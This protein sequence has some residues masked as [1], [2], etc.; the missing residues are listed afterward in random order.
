MLR[1][2]LNILAA[3]ALLAAAPSGSAA[4]EGDLFGKQLS[5][6]P[7]T[8]HADEV[9]YEPDRD[10][11]EAVGHVRIEQEGGGTL[12]A[13]WLAFNATTRVG[14]A[15]GNVRI[16]D[17]E[18]TLVADF[19]AVD[20]ETLVAI[21]TDAVLD[22][23]ASGFVVEGDP[24]HKTGTNTYRVED[25]TFTTCRCPP[26][27]KCRPWEIRGKETDVRVGGYGVARHATF[28]VLNLPVL[29]SPWFV[30]PVKTERQT[31]FL[32]PH[33]SS[34]SRSGLGLEIPFFWAARDNVN[35]LLRPNYYSKR[36]FKG[37]V[38]LEYLF[39]ETG[40]GSGGAAILP[41]DNEVEDGD[42]AT[43]Y[44]DNRWAYWLRHHHPLGDGMRF[45]IDLKRVSDND[46]VVDFEDLPSQ[47]R[48]ARFL[49][50]S[51]WGGAAEGAFYANAEL[52]HFDDLQS[53][54]NLDRDD[55]ML[56][57]LPDVQLASLPRRLGP[58]PLWA[59]V[60]ARYIYF[61]QEADRDTVAGRSAV[62]GQFFDTGQDGLFDIQEQ[63][64][65][66]LDPSQDNGITERDGFFQ[67]GE[68]LA[69]HGHR[70]ELYPRL[71]LP[72]RFGIVETLSEVGFR[73]TLY[74]ASQGGSERRE[75]WTGRFD[76]RMRFER[77][78]ALGSTKLHH[79]LEP[80]AAFALVSTP[81][82]DGNPLFIPQG[83]VPQKRLI[84]GDVRL[85]AR[86]PS[87]RI[88]DE[89][90]LELAVGNRFFAAPLS[91]GQPPRLVAEL[92]LG[93]GYDFERSRMANIYLTGSFLLW[94]QLGLYGELGY[95]PKETRL[96]EAGLALAW[97]SQRGDE[98][99]I[100]Y[101]FL[102]D[103]NAGFENFSVSDD[104][105]DD[106]EEDFDRVSQLSAEGRW[107]ISPRLEL[108][109]S[110]Y[111]SFDESSTRS[112]AV[113]VVLRSRCDC[114]ELIGEVERSQRP[115]NTSF[116]L[117]INL[118]GLGRTF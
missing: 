18:D 55:F 106:F 33:Q 108:F 56:Q 97:E 16:R 96:E 101:R 65:P 30:V 47:T 10:T 41:G 86:D 31:G 29:Y 21:A 38:E 40:F 7:F 110:G 32:I 49:E 62:N 81:E 117:K 60:G 115:S 24:I 114:W 66:L 46:Y 59:G 8:L 98:L 77:S 13:D 26:G 57:R 5:E 19:A 74:W 37:G 22:A 118:T 68:L 90:F 75:I 109:G 103:F 83:S 27:S 102:R 28:R 116:S 61:Y 17:G 76:A 25:G 4:Q 35:V 111:Y 73:E 72:L 89:R 84:D 54:E 2:L 42:P 9:S 3:A 23:G 11:Y 6:A 82:Q 87:D 92:R 94:T 80:K 70:L 93:S 100:S 71:S 67:E 63:G 79:L 69:D 45:G 14:V 52:L 78:L 112:G 99:S 48:H 105:F 113:G 88:P 34:D 95:D 1:V 64:D 58:L 104:V 107:L 53:P 51:A 20:L 39:G 91:D 36:G 43:P 85:L 12:T 15:S 44:S 50:S